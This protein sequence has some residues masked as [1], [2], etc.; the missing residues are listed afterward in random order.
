MTQVRR[1][2]S[3]LLLLLCFSYSQGQQTV[4]TSTNVVVPPVMNFS[5][6]LTDVNGKPLT[7]V[8]GVTFLLYQESE[9]GVPLWME[10]QNV[11]PDKTGHYT[12]ILGSTS[13]QGLPADIFVAGQAHWLAV[14]VQGQ[15]E[16]PRVLLVSAPYALKRGMRTLS[17]DCRPRPSC[18]QTGPRKTLARVLLDPQLLPQRKRRRPPIRTLPARARWTT[19]RCGTRRAISWTR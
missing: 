6:V 7:G 9:A 12:V 17:A 13:S 16:Q 3:S 10:T 18:Y 15:D 8:T 2:V 14:Q 1:V 11:Q 5:G 19:S 4:S